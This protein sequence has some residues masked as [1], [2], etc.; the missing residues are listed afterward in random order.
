MIRPLMAR[1][2][3]IA[4]F[5]FALLSMGAGSGSA[6]AGDLMDAISNMIGGNTVDEDQYQERSPL[7]VP[8]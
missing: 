2:P 7:V 3:L 5:G 1:V 8:P 4:L 6:K